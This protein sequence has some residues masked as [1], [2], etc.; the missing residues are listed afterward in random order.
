MEYC[1]LSLHQYITL[2]DTTLENKI[3]VIYQISNVLN[4]IHG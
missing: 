3:D 4:Y 1:E 2:P